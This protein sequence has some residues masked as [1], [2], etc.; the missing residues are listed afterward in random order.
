MK[1]AISPN[2][3]PIVGTFEKVHA[4]AKTIITDRD[5]NG[6]LIWDHEGGSEIFWDSMETQTKD[7][8]IVFLDVDGLEWTEDEITFVDD[9]EEDGEDEAAT[10]STETPEISS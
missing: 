6:E 7:G 4:V 10:G 1:V 5:A 8:K 2:G 3:S 9:D